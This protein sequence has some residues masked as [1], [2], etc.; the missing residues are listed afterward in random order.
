MT[1]IADPA[2]LPDIV[3]S[4]VANVKPTAAT[5]DAEIDPNRWM[6]VYSFE[7][8]PSADYGSATE[9]STSIGADN[10]P[11]PVSSTVNDL[12]PGTL[13]HFRVVAIN[14]SGTTYG[15]DQVF[16]T[17]DAP[18]VE[19]IAV[20]AVTRTT[21]YLESLVSPNA[22]NTTVR[23]EYG[24]TVGYGSSSAS[25][26]IAPDTAGHRVTADLSG[27]EP[28]TTYHVRAVAS[29]Q[30]GTISGPDQTFATAPPEKVAPSS[31]TLRCKRGF[32]KR[33]GKCVKRRKHHSKRRRHATQRNG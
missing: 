31:S 21:A 3:S 5:F 33:R 17:P 10:E 18:R 16:F 11:H 26:A 1:F 14:Y 2:P 7:Y 8:G 13:Y 6:T 19:T 29:N 12:V 20:T 30:Y 22:G 23:F 15:P 9:T 32:V 27:L 25:T 4:S 24:T 28:G